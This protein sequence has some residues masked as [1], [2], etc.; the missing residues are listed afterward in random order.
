MHD[1]LKRAARWSAVLWILALAW[2]FFDPDVPAGH[3]PDD[4]KVLIAAWITH[5]LLVTVAWGLLV[6]VL[7][8]AAWCVRPR[9]PEGGQ[10]TTPTPP[11]ADGAGGKTGKGGPW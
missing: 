9:T 5:A 8:L 4:T 1:V 3:D 10:G 7:R 11:A 6:A 2:G